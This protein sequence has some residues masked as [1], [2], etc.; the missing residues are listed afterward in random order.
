MHQLAPR[1]GDF[2]WRPQVG[3]HQAE[4]AEFCADRRFFGLPYSCTVIYGSFRDPEGVLFTPMRRL[5]S[6]DGGK[7]RLLVQST[8]DGAK[9]CEFIP[10]ERRQ[11]AAPDGRRISETGC[12]TSSLPHSRLTPR[13]AWSVMG[14]RSSG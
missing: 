5:Y 13:F 8:L 1:R 10:Q 4:P 9:G 2:R 11:P 12:V 3:A 14:Q 6:G 7:E